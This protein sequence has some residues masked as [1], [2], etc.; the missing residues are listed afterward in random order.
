MQIEERFCF[1]LLLDE[2]VAGVLGLRRTHAV[3]DELP[4]PEVAATHAFRMPFV[5]QLTPRS[6]SRG[7]TLPGTQADTS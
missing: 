3:S 6:L 1:F 7:A 4:G 2:R 5:P